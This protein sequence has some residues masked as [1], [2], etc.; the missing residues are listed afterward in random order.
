MRYDVPLIAQATGM[1]CWAASIA[2]ILGWK[3]QA[4]FDP[5]Q[6]A[7]NPGGPSY[8]PSLTSGLDPNDRYILGRNGFVLEAPVCYT[9]QAISD[10][11]DTYGPL[12][13]ASQAPLSGTGGTAPHIRVVTGLDGGRVHVNDPWPVNRG[14]RYSSNFE[15][16][17]GE[18][19][20]LGANERREPNPVY[21][22][23]LDS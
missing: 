18:M 6:I 17:F 4:S 15:T 16:I 1:G 13:L 14:A 22:A 8:V 10:L 12:W 2:M 21:V 7:A 19:E 3:N 23:H 5:S 11:L 20:T 9:P